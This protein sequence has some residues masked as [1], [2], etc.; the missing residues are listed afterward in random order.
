MASSTQI[1]T[2][3]TRLD[4]SLMT[5]SPSPNQRV[6]ILLTQA[7]KHGTS[8]FFTERTFYAPTKALSAL[9]LCLVDVPSYPVRSL[10]KVTVDILD[11]SNWRS[12]PVRDVGAGIAD[13]LRSLYQAALIASTIVV[14]IIIPR[15]M[16]GALII[17]E[18]VQEADVDA[19][20]LELKGNIQQ[21]SNLLQTANQQKTAL[22]TRLNKEK[23]DLQIQVDGLKKGN[24]TLSS[25]LANLQSEFNKKNEQLQ[26]LGKKTK[27]DTQK[28]TQEKQA[29]LTEINAL[30][31]AIAGLESKISQQQETIGNLSKEREDLK[32]QIQEMKDAQLEKGVIVSPKKKK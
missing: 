25:Q 7:Q 11:F 24:Q 13:G 15:I 28:S 10:H 31:E 26:N 3:L 23:A 14:G 20:I 8:Q 17:S 27:E 18:T 12:A 16:Y 19:Q 4:A 9:A 32:K 21:I 1:T 22:E 30:K 6:N 2:Y 5:F 29:F